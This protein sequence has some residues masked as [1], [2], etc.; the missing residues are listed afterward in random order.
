L[1]QGV[2]LCDQR[3][4]LPPAKIELPEEPLALADTELDTE[5]FSDV[6]AEELSV[7]EVLVITERPGALP[8]V[9]AQGHHGFLVQRAWPSGL[10]FLPEAGKATLL[11]P[12]NPTLDRPG[13]VPKQPRYFVTSLIGGCL[14]MRKYLWRSV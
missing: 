3:P 10:F 8:Q 9:L 7:P 13:A 11:E 14:L 1:G 2:S 12:V 6:V 5:L 4:G